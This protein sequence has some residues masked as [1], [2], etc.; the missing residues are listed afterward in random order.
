MKILTYPNPILT[1]VSE[2]VTEFGEELKNFCD[3]LHTTMIKSDGAGLSA[4]QVGVLKRI[5]VMQVPDGDKHVFINPQISICS[6][7]KFPYSEGCLSVPGYFEERERSTAIWLEYDNAEGEY[8]EGWF[9]G[10]E[11]FCIQHELDHLEGKLFIDDLSPLKKDRIR[12]KIQKTLRR[13]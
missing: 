7:K 10:L 3:E 5:V 8:Q 13:K 2:P 1:Q 9:H 4:V 11:A 6:E 12:K